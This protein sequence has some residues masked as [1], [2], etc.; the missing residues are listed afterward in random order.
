MDAEP[1]H[2]CKNCGFLMHIAES[3][4]INCQ[5]LESYAKKNVA[6]AYTQNYKYLQSPKDFRRGHTRNENV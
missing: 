2:N 1:L 5:I 6:A 4:C 3:E